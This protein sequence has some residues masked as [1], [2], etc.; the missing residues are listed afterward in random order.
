MSWRGG[1]KGPSTS[2]SEPQVSPRTAKR[3]KLQEERLKRAEQRDKLRKQVQEAQAAQVEADKTVQQ[4]L[5]LEP[6]LLSGEDTFVSEGEVDNLL[7]D[8]SVD[9]QPPAGIED[10]V[11]DQPPPAEAAIMVD[12]EEQNEDDS[13]T[14]MDN[15]RGIHCPFN[16]E[17][18]VFW[19]SQ[20]EDQLTLI[21]VKKQWTKNSFGQISS[22]RNSK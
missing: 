16:K 7:A 8:D 6:D 11:V 19:F 15:L 2:K 17:D 14:A 4:L 21:G 10:L 5:A 20:L 22:P 9:Q 12:F 3:N 1:Y 13:A 18:I